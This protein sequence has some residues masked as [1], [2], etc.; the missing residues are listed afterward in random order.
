LEAK[1]NQE[2]AQ[3]H[4]AFGCINVVEATTTTLPCVKRKTYQ[5][6]IGTNTESIGGLHH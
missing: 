6:G 1:K 3:L 2:H 5:R 4:I